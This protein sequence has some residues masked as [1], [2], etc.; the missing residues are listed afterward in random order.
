[1]SDQIVSVDEE[2]IKKELRELVKT[3]V[4]QTI[5][6]L[7][8]EEAD[9]LVGAERYERTASRDAYRSGHYKRKLLT[10]SGEIELEVPKLRRHLPDRRHRALLQT[11]DQ[12]RR[13]HDGDVSRRCFHQAN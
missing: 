5:N 2:A 9:E 1:M 11:R 12:R 4:E 3:T 13:S 6:A 10:T 7:L 8:D